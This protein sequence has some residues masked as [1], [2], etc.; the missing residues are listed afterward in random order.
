RRRG[1]RV[2]AAARGP[3]HGHARPAGG[4]PHP[5][6]PRPAPRRRPWLADAR[7][8]AGLAALSPAAHAARGRVLRPL[9]GA[10]A[11]LVAAAGARAA[12]HVGRRPAPR[13]LD[14]WRFA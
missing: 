8:T 9:A 4:A 10:V 6:R 3:P 5:A 11:H 13:A 1:G 12:G 14:G 7:S 2:L